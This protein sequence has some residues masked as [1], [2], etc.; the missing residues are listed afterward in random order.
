MTLETY[1]NVL[2]VGAGPAGLALANAL[3]KRPGLN[4]ILAESGV[5]PYSAPKTSDRS[6]TIDITGHG[7]KAIRYLNATDVLNE[8]LIKFKG[9]LLFKPK[10]RL[11]PWTNDGWTGSRGDILQA[12]LEAL[13]LNSE[14]RVEVLWNTKVTDVRPLTGTAR[15]GGT[16]RSFDLIVGADGAGSVVRDSCLKVPGF[17]V[18]TYSLN[19]YSI[20][21]KMDQNTE[22]FDPG[23]LHV[24]NAW[25]FVIFGAVNGESKGEQDWFCLLGFNHRHSFKGSCC[26]YSSID[27]PLGAAKKYMQ[28]TPLLANCVSDEELRNLIQRGCHHVG[29]G[30]KCSTFHLGKAV[31]IGDAAAP[32]PPIGQ[33]I[34]AALESAVVLDGAIEEFTGSKSTENL[35]MACAKYSE[36]WLPEAHAALWISSRYSFGSRLDALKL[37]IADALG[38]PVIDQ[39]KFQP[40]SVVLNNAKSL[41]GPLF[42]FTE[43]KPDQVKGTLASKHP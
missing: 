22:D 32:F 16:L 8:R 17:T 15:V 24:A 10:R 41:L 30:A 13:K 20:M 7:L 9:M 23:I 35:L 21:V 27:D 5:D 38:L 39:A 11:L 14:S 34:N 2:I 37:M 3:S 12:L 33:G 6:Y 40:Y 25:P 36:I 42:R 29:R 4:V 19:N 28:A 18:E 31:L 1:L 26:K 43:M